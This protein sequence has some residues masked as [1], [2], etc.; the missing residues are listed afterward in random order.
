[1]VLVVLF[2]YSNKLQSM[3]VDYS[4]TDMGCFG[5]YLDAVPHAKTMRGNGITTFLLYIY[6]CILMTL[7]FYLLCCICICVPSFGTFTFFLVSCPIPDFYSK[8]PAF[9]PIYCATWDSTRGTARG[10]RGVGWGGG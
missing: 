10:T 6:Q 5:D 9:M 8:I 4:V 2:Y 3:L 1:M 7:L